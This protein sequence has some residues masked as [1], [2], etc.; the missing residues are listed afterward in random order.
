[1]LFIGSRA[2]LSVIQYMQIGHCIHWLRDRSRCSETG[3][4]ITERA[5]AEKRREALAE[6]RL[7]AF[8]IFVSA[9]GGSSYRGPPKRSALLETRA[10]E[11][12]HWPCVTRASCDSDNVRIFGTLAPRIFEECGRHARE[13]CDNFNEQK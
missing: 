7:V 8:Q 6:K 3:S 10:S 4:W 11:Q 12:E 2:C 9:Q 1:M 5:T 13:P